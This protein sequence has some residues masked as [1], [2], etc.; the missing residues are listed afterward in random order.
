MNELHLRNTKENGLMLKLKLQYFGPNVKNW[1]SGKDPDAKKDRRQEDKGITEDEMAGYHHWLNG[2]EFEQAPGV[3]DGQGSLA[4]CSPWDRKE[5]NTTECL[6][7]ELTE[8]EFSMKILE[9]EDLQRLW[10]CL[11]SNNWRSAMRTVSFIC[12][13]EIRIPYL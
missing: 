8:R 13:I 4:C 3:G 11:Y 12:N 10:C 6:W 5:L 9:K 2:H 1:L 7:T